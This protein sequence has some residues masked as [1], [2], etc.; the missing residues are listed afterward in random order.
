[1]FVNSDY[2]TELIVAIDINTRDTGNIFFQENEII[3]FYNNIK[4]LN[5]DFLKNINL[6][7]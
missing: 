1:M 4:L 3:V 2:K 6:G 5:K 7:E